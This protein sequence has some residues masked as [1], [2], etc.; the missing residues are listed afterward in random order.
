MMAA[1]DSSARRRRERRLR[2]WW[3]HEAPAAAC[4][5]GP[6]SQKPA[7]ARE[8]PTSF[9]LFDEEDVGGMRPQALVEPEPLEW[10]QRR[11]V[12]QTVD[13]PQVVLSLDEPVSQVV[14]QLTEVCRHLDFHLPEQ[15][16][17]VPKI[18]SSSRC[19][20]TVL[21]APQTA[22]Q[23]VEVP[24]VCI[25]FIAGAERRHSGS[26]WWRAICWSSRFLHSTELNSAAVF[27]GAHF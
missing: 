18:S 27:Y 8:E 20:R 7:R 24:T 23:L 6:R 3:R 2:S 14:D 17:D 4:H 12:V 10:D 21:N 9:Q 5:S 16:T 1:C 22:E 15:V 25:L 11:T 19:L 26:L 13:S